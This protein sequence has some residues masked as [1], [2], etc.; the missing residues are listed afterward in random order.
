MFWRLRHHPTFIIEPFASGAAADLMKVPRGENAGL[1]A[2]KLTELGKQY[3][4]NGNIDA[5]TQRV[6]A[7]ND[8]EQSFLRELFDEHAILR[9]QP[10]MVQTDAMPEPFLDVGTV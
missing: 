1:L 9:E 3:G 10:C 2:V 5:D 7:A 6:R 8:F 4:A